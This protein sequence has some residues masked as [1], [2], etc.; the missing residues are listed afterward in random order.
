MKER[1]L[2]IKRA[3]LRYNLTHDNLDGEG[4]I[5]VYEVRLNGCAGLVVAEKKLISRLILNLFE[6]R[7]PKGYRVCAYLML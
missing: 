4:F 3:R 7:G 2:K 5:F 1:V 6:C